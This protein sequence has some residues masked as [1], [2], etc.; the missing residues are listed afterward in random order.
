[1]VSAIVAYYGDRFTE[2]LSRVQS[3]GDMAQPQSGNDLVYAET[4]IADYG[5]EIR[6]PVSRDGHYWVTIHVN[7]T[8]VRF[9][10]DTGASHVSLSY[11]DAK[12]VGLD[13]EELSFDRVFMTANGQSQKAMITLDH[14]A[15]QSIQM[16]NV[17][18]SVS[19]PGRM[20]VSL[21]GMNFLNDLSGFRIENGEL[22][23]K[24]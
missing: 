15:L 21:L 6:I 10:V 23:L 5:R 11:R 12:A 8:P 18:A 7:S 14:M 1:M 4:T 24:P 20:N 13:P 17:S 9:V 2:I 22:I 3:R 16:S 19:R